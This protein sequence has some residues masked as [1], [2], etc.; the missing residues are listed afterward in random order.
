MQCYKEFETG[1]SECGTSADTKKLQEHQKELWT[2]WLSCK[3]RRRGQENRQWK[4]PD[5]SR[6]S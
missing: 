2:T 6:A 5:E 3:Q 1:G 4:A